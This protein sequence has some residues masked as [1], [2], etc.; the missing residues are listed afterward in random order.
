MKVK[1]YSEE[2]SRRVMASY[3]SPGRNKVPDPQHYAK[4]AIKEPIIITIHLI[5]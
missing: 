3:F 1:K 5:W 4:L 2:I